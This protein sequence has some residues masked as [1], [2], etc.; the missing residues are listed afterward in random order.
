MT[1]DAEHTLSPRLV[2]LQAEYESARAAERAAQA[3]IDN[4]QPRNEL[5][6]EQRYEDLMRA[7]WQI[8]NAPVTNAADLALKLRVWSETIRDPDNDSDD[9]GDIEGDWMDCAP[10]RLLTEARQV[11]AAGQA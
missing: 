2:E 3:A 9:T 8:V 7:T 1:N 5:E 10:F 4:G 11:L 6:W